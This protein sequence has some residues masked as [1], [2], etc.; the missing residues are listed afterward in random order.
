MH[1]NKKHLLKMTF[2]GMIAGISTGLVLYL[3]KY[4]TMILVNQMTK[5]YLYVSSHPWYIP[6]FFLGLA[7]LSLLIYWLVKSEKHAQ[8]GAISRAMGILRGLIT[9]KWLRVMI[10][11]FFSSL[12]GFFAGLPVGVEGPSVMIGTALGEGTHALTKS[13]PATKRYIQTSGASAGFAIATGSLLA[14][15][16]YGVE[17]MHKKFSF[18]IFIS[19]MIGALFATITARTLDLLFGRGEIFF[20]IGIV[21]QLPA[22]YMWVMIIVGILAGVMA[23]LFNKLVLVSGNFVRTRLKKVPLY[24]KILINLGLVGSIGL[25]VIQTVGSGHDLIVELTEL[26]YSW[27]MVLLFLIL[28]LITITVTTNSG[29]TG[30]LF[31]PVLV[32]GA[33][34]GALLN[35][36]FLELGMSFSYSKIIIVATMC[37]F[38]GSSMQAPL[39]TLVFIIEGTLDVNNI[40]ALVIAM[41]TSLI[42]S[43]I[44]STGSLNEVVLNNI[45][46]KQN[47]GKE[48]L[49]YEIEAKI[50][51]KAFADGFQVRDLLLPANCTITTIKKEKTDTVSKLIKGGD[52]LLRA[53]DYVVFQVQTY[54]IEET[55]QELEAIIGKQKLKISRL[56]V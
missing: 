47:D 32:I 22:K 34:A 53:E 43:Y 12:I 30:G 17:E 3:F 52:K 11:T 26:K 1:R 24:L 4:L 23:A 38:F 21:E 37:A 56:I 55:K 44:L 42:V 39:T 25:L 16:V 2:I 51:N 27:Y 46:R 31:V 48:A 7:V 13:D 8:G 33:L 9:F 35:Q 45:L 29:T 15:M 50:Q 19:S 18:T 54:D 5:I 40:V 14:G 41:A 28:K 10:I 6:I 49:T 36:V 20:P